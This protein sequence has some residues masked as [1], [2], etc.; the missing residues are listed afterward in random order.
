MRMY[1]LAN[2][3]LNDFF[4]HPPRKRERERESTM[5]GTCVCVFCTSV[6]IGRISVDLV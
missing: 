2:F 3:K 5:R 4:V 6:T 1:G